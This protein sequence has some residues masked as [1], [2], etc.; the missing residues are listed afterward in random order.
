MAIGEFELI[1]RYFNTDCQAGAR[2]VALGIG[3][4]CALLQLPPNQ[5]LAVS[6]DTL[7]AGVHFPED[8]EPAQLAQRALRVNLSDLAAMGA[9]PLWFTLGLTLPSADAA[10]LQAFSQGLFEVANEYGCTL[11]GGDTTRGPL[12]VSIHVHGGVEAGQALTRSQ[13]SVGDR[14]YVT[15]TLGDAAAALAVMQGRLAV[16]EPAA[17]YLMG[18][19]YRPQPQVRAG[20]RLRGLASACIDISDGLLADLGHICNNSGVGAEVDVSQMPLSPPMAQQVSPEQALK[21]ALTGGDDYQ[22][23]FTV[24]ADKAGALQRLIEQGEVS[25][26]AIGDIVAGVGVTCIKDGKAVPVTKTG[27]QHFESGSA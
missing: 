18:R 22:L 16:D 26:T 27:Y 17:D 8:A 3:D 20:Q 5:Q 1:R 15:G 19:Y 7:V 13:A 21:W 12:S 11:V 6:L 2:G 10:W 24:P 4:D 23:C 9:E 25:A 14:I